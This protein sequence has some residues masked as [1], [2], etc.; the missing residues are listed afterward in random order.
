MNVLISL[1]N[2]TPS[3]DANTNIAKLIAAQ[4]KEGNNVCMLGT[5]FQQASEKE[6][7]DGVTYYRILRI[8]KEKH[9]KLWQE[10][11]SLGN[12]SQKIRFILKHP[13]YFAGLC[14]RH[15]RAKFTDV[16][17]KAYIKK[18]K[19]IEKAE[20]IDRVIVITSPFYIVTAVQKAI[21]NAEVVWYQLDPNQSNI[22][23][24]YKGK[25][26]LLEKEKSVYEFVKYAVIPRLVYE[27][28]MQNEL[29]VYKEK[30]LPAEFPN[31]RKLSV[32]SVDDDVCFDE[33]KINLVF[34]GVFYEDIRNPVSLFEIISKT[35]NED[36]VLNIVGGGCEEIV[37]EWAAKFPNKIIR[38]GY[39]SLEA[40]LNAMQRADILVNV[41]N[42]AK[43]MLPSK[44]ND[45]ISTGKP[46]VNLH[47]FEDNKTIEYFGKYQLHHNLY[48]GNICEKSIK[49]FED[50]CIENKGKNVDIEEIIENYKEST[51]E[52][53]SALLLKE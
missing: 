25:T 41:D 18:L 20:R 12:K 11:S 52:Y 23:T 21:K 53:V 48:M 44:V 42:T 2:I 22:T 3:D 15:M 33:T 45:Y 26:D 47:P 17:E 35:K 40:A 43:N 14:F 24:I 37:E 13:L 31:V 51:A 49:A 34:V 30:M 16:S 38:H 10:W 7:V 46:I 6:V 39:R 8:E 5:A 19:E 27:E 1:G 29:S 32:V 4:I 36:I 9:K 28:N 50:F